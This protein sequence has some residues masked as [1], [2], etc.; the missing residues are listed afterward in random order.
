MYTIDVCEIRRAC[1]SASLTH[2]TENKSRM[3]DVMEL[4]DADDADVAALSSDLPAVKRRIAELVRVLDSFAALRDPRRSRSDYVTQLKADC[5]L[6]YGYNAFMIDTLFNLFSPVECLELIE[7]NESR[8]PVTLR[9]NT[10]KTRRREL[11]AALIDR[12]VNLDPMGKWTKVGLVVYESSVPVGATP[13]YMAGHYMLQARFLLSVVIFRSA[14]LGRNRSS[15][16]L[17]Q[18]PVQSVC[19]QV[20]AQVLVCAWRGEKLARAVVQTATRTAL[21]QQPCNC[22]CARSQSLAA[23]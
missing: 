1:D 5:M 20:C 11:A 7:A 9:A 17:A 8:R 12:G 22:E 16:L 4:P 2:S 10:L 3:Q 23:C 21:Q 13:E 18:S 15:M 14:A 19:E 6:Y